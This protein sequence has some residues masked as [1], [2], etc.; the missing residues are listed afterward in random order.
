MLRVGQVVLKRKKVLS[1]SILSKI[2]ADAEI[3][4]DFRIETMTA[5]TQR[6]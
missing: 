1:P 6:R 2:E 4:G 5:E 3:Y